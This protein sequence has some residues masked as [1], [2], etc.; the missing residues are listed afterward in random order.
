MSFYKVNLMLIHIIFI[1]FFLIPFSSQENCQDIFAS[2]SSECILSEEDKLSYKYCCYVEEDYGCSPYTEENY[3]TDKEKYE[4]SQRTFKC[5]DASVKSLPEVTWNGCEDISPSKSSDCVMSQED[6]N[7]GYE[8]CCY[9]KIDSFAVCTLD[10]KES[11]QDE[12]DYIKELGLKDDTVYECNDKVGEGDA[13]YV[14]CSIILLILAI[15]L[16]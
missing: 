7:N 6:K 10:T 3:L 11:Y 12:L 2:E 16:I 9:E 1:L 13:G 4:S 14:N 5:N 15:F 8:L